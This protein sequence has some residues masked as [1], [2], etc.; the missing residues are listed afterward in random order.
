MEVRFVRPYTEGER[1]TMKDI[2]KG[3]VMLPV[4][5]IFSPLPIMHLIFTNKFT[6]TN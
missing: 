6:F 1:K 3:Q 2:G 5:K 4:V